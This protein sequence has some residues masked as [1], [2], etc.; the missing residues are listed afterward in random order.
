MPRLDL[1]FR[2]LGDQVG[3]LKTQHCRNLFDGLEAGIVDTS[4]KRADICPVDACL[5]R[6]LLLRQAFRLPGCPKIYCEDLPY[7]HPSDDKSSRCI[8]PRSILDIAIDLSQSWSVA[9]RS[10]DKSWGWK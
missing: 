7:V 3:W 9:R 10:I 8:S 2:I 4:F 1:A 6:K 5:V